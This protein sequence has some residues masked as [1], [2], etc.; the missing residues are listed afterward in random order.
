MSSINCLSLLKDWCNLSNKLLK[1]NESFSISSPDLGLDNLMSRFSVVIS[2]ILL[3]INEIGLIIRWVNNIA[4][5]IIGNIKITKI[6][7][8][9]DI[10]EFKDF[11]IASIGWATKSTSINLLST[12]VGFIKN[13]I[14]VVP[15]FWLIK[16]I[17]L[18]FCAIL[19]KLL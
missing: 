4:P 17:D 16:V 14:G 15:M 8:K 5:K 3:I 13:L 7:I 6:I 10:N 2:S 19:N 9:V 12:H 18:F 11:C 1:V